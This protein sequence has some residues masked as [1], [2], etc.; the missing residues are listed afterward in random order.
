[1]RPGAHRSDA[2]LW[3]RSGAGARSATRAASCASSG[4]G[5][6]PGPCGASRR[7][8]PSRARCRPSPRS[9]P[10]ASAAC[11]RPARLRASL[12]RMPHRFAATFLQPS[13]AFTRCV[14]G[15][16]HSVGRR[17][18]APHRSRGPEQPSTRPLERPP[19]FLASAHAPRCGQEPDAWCTQA[20]ELAGHLVLYGQ[21]QRP[22][23]IAGV[24]AAVA[25]VAA[26]RRRGAGAGGAAL[27]ELGGQ[28]AAEPVE[29]LRPRVRLRGRCMR[30]GRPRASGCMSG[31][32]RGRRRKRV[33]RTGDRRVPGTQ[34]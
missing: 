15:I 32:L 9:R 30:L 26:A 24:R 19:A 4:T 22:L 6:L 11:E 17:R 29:R 25:R 12:Q 33:H 31:A 7:S 34:S 5:A 20:A 1:M 16:G 14:R 23:V 2:V 8:A 3:T 18:P 27:R 10:S 13:R 28:A 21:A